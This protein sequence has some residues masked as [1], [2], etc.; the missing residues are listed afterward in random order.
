MTPYL[1]AILLALAALVGFLS[2]TYFETGRGFRLLARPRRR[3]DR[4]V[5][6][7]AFIIAH[8]DLGGFTR[9][10][11]RAAAE[12]LLHDIAHASLLI[13]RFIERFLTR[14]VRQLRGRREEGTP[15]AVP[16][17]SFR[18]AVRHVKSTIRLRRLAIREKED[19]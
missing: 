5:G 6:Q 14:F 1:I 3:L 8:V 17:R 12:R 7:A 10:T 9:D 4:R 15:A 13:V 19:E 11:L 2:L 18:E 16:R